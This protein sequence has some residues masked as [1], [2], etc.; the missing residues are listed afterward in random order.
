MGS[1]DKSELAR[2]GVGESQAGKERDE[3]LQWTKD[4]DD[5]LE[6]SKWEAKEGRVRRSLIS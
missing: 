1:G 5:Q 2:E 6:P 4:D 3:W